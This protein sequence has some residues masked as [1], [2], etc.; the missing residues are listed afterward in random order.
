[1][2]A[3]EITTEQSEYLATLFHNQSMLILGG[4][5]TG[6]SI[7]ALEAVKR[8]IKKNPESKILY[9]C[10]NAEFKEQIK[11]QIKDELIIGLENTTVA[12]FSGYFDIDL[13]K[14]FGR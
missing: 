3:F 14:K 12:T 11:G 7:L 6:K 2:K 10:S 13:K 4:A 8:Q 9:L 1:M 5:G